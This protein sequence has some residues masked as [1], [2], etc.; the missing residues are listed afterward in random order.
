MI[1]INLLLKRIFLV[2]GNYLKMI[3]HIDELGGLSDGKKRELL[4]DGCRGDLVFNKCGRQDLN[5]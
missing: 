1:Y 5:E 3:N 2:L 4:L